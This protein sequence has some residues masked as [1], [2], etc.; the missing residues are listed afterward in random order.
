MIRVLDFAFAHVWPVLL[1]GVAIVFPSEYLGHCFLALIVGVAA[2]SRFG[3]GRRVPTVL[4]RQ[5]LIFFI[6][7]LAGIVWPSKAMDRRIELGTQVVMLGDLARIARCQLG[8]GVDAGAVIRLDRSDPRRKHLAGAI[9]TQTEYLA[10]RH[11]PLC[12]T[13]AGIL[14]GGHPLGPLWISLRKDP[15]QVSTAGGVR[16]NFAHRVDTEGFPVASFAVTPAENRL[17]A[18]L[19]FDDGEVIELDRLGT[20]IAPRFEL[21]GVECP[22]GPSART[23][24]LGVDQASGWMRTLLIEFDHRG[25]RESLMKLQVI[26]DRLHPG[27]QAPLDSM[28]LGSNPEICWILES[29][30]NVWGWARNEGRLECVVQASEHPQFAEYQHL[31]NS[32]E[33]AGYGNDWV[34]VEVSAHSYARRDEESVTYLGDSDKDGWF[35]QVMY[36]GDL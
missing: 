31:Y 9:R 25:K 14:F 33:E 24:L 12:G 23:L 19:R 32:S 18:I 2:Q 7:M 16:T 21:V 11:L 17:R 5:V 1:A 10:P 28:M 26:E 20:E 27:M 15:G 36:H 34:H 8:E 4:V 22:H 30:G 3:V 29:G 13:G 6:V 35:D